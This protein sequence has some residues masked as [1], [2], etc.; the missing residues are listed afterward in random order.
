[1][2]WATNLPDGPLI[3]FRLFVAKLYMFRLIVF[4]PFSGR[5]AWR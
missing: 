3:V 5:Q 1:M 2:S 4:K